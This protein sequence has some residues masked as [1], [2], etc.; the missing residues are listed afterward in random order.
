MHLFWQEIQILVDLYVITCFG[1]LLGLLYVM[2]HAMVHMTD[3]PA[4]APILAGSNGINDRC[5]C[6]FSSRLMCTNHAPVLAG[7]LNF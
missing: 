4:V 7:N 6:S 3:I 1:T 5:S 2:P